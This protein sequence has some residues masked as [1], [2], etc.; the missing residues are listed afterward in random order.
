MYSKLRTI[1]KSMEEEEQGL[2]AQ[3]RELRNQSRF[4]EAHILEV[5]AEAVHNSIIPLCVIVRQETKEPI[6]T[7][8]VC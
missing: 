2:I 4:Y 8:T 5:K 3:S 6:N 1:I 7:N